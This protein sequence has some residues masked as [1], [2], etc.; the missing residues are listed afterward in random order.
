[1]KHHMQTTFK[2]GDLINAYE[3]T[4]INGKPALT[5]QLQGFF[6]ITAPI[7]VKKAWQWVATSK[8]QTVSFLTLLADQG[9]TIKGLYNALMLR[10]ICRHSARIRAQKQVTDECMLWESITHAGAAEVC[11]KPFDLHVS[12]IVRTKLN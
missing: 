11:S 1:V 2:P 6:M 5:S 12:E 3:R 4:Y 8:K 7:D 9:Y 10:R